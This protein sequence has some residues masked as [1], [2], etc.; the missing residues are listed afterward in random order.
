[1]LL[2]LFACPALHLRVHSG[3]TSKLQDDQASGN[4]GV[5]LG[6]RAVGGCGCWGQGGQ[7]GIMLYRATSMVAG[8]QWK[9]NA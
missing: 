8:R 1:M 6:E 7:Q 4:V 5:C 3:G 2:L 9:D